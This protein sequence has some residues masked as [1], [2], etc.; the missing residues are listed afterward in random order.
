MIIVYK[1]TLLAFLSVLILMASFLSLAK[2][3]DGAQVSILKPLD[4]EVVNQ[5]FRVKFD[6]KH[7]DL[8]PAGTYKINTGHHHLLIDVEKMPDFKYPI[9]SDGHHLH[10]GGGQTEALIQLTPGNHDLQLIL[11][12]R[13]HVPHDS[14]LISKKITVKVKK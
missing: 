10:F 6:I 8:A 9:P 11:G 12:D 5:T 4:G 14:P 7:F 13:F 2:E 3:E 1:K